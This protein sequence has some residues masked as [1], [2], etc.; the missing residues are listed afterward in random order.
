MT[1]TDELANAYNEGYSQAWVQRGK[2]QN[3][4]DCYIPVALPWHL[5]KVGDTVRQPARIVDGVEVEPAKLWNIKTI[6]HKNAHRRVSLE[7]Q[8]GDKTLTAGIK[9]GDPGLDPQA[10][11]MVLEAAPLAQAEAVL[12]AQFTAARTLERTTG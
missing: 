10:L 9:K 8:W 1:D 7:A 2:L 6:N 5:V 11:I 12:R 4:E 3:T